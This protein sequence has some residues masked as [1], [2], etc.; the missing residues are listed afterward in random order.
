[1]KILVTG[2]SGFVGSALCRMLASRRFGEVLAVHRRQPSMESPRGVTPVFAS[3]LDTLVASL[4]GVDVVV[5]LAARV[6]QMNDEAA[7]P[8]DAF[9]QVNTTASCRL[10][11]AAG[12][13]GVRRFIYLSSVK[14][15]GEH[16]APG[17]PFTAA[18][19]P[20]PQD[21]YGISKAEAESIL[22]RLHKAGGPEMVIIRPPLVYGPGVK[23][24]FQ[25]MMR[26]VHAGIPLPFGSVDNRRS[27][28]AIE[29]LCDLIGRCV[30]HPE[31]AGQTFM[32]SD[33]EDLS[34]SELLRRTGRAL[35]RPARLLPIPT[36]WMRT[37][38]RAMG[39]QDLAQRLLGSLQVD[40]SPAR[41]R[42]GWTPVV[43]VNDA[44][45]AT[46]EFYLHQ[47]STR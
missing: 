28:V 21:P 2:A 45:K 30:D 10:A 36:S 41:E 4:T 24:N 25:S 34:T 23:A 13:A 46:A 11:E 19:T 7:D 35:G 42:L 40:I 43:R 47:V 31:A 26:W 18:D 8:L 39:K 3:D 32:V 15:N 27:L 14:V 5:H 37:T 9:R 22:M 1:M 12:E 16:T 17:K 20:S 29:N 38:A 44:L 33:G 6:H